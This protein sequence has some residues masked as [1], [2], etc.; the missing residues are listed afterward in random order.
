MVYKPKKLKSY[1]QWIGQF[2]WSLRKGKID[3]LLLDNKGHFVCTIKVS[4]PG[5]NEVVAHSVRK[6]EQKL[7]DRGLI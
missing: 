4:H 7:K 3:W 5:T 1:Q 2:G 6:T